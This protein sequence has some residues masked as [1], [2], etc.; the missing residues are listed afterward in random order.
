LIHLPSGPGDDGACEFPRLL[1]AI[2]V[3]LAKTI[4]LAGIFVAFA[5]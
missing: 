2:L 3:Q 4:C 1:H 5:V